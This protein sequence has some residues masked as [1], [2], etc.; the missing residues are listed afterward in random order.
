LQESKRLVK[1]L[2]YYRNA[3]N[4][5][6]SRITE[7][8]GNQNQR[9]FI[10]S[11]KVEKI[12]NKI[13]S[14]DDIFNPFLKKNYNDYRLAKSDLMLPIKSFAHPIMEFSTDD[15]A[16]LFEPTGDTM[17][18]FGIKSDT[19]LHLKLLTKD[20]NRQLTNKRITKF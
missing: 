12:N 2:I 14:S 13:A 16:I 11:D 4:A 3:L 5:E 19:H 17:K 1:L 10:L 15:K 9:V 6:K 18:F 7:K 8:Y 20:V